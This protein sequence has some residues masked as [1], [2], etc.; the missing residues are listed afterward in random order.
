[1]KICQLPIDKVSPYES[2]PRENDHAVAKVAASLE[3]FGWQQPIVIDSDSVII[4]GHT[5]WLAAKSLDM[6]KVPCV[7]AD[8]LS[9]E[10]VKAYRIAD[11]RIAAES[12]WNVELLKAELVGLKDADYDL[13]LTGFDENE[14]IKYLVDSNAGL[15]EPD[16]VPDAP[17]DPVTQPGDLWLFGA[18]WECDDCGKRYDYEDG[19]TMDEC[20]C[21]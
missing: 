10:Q 16:E 20:P 3:Q 15:A 21:G 11:N 18:Y 19:K 1:V 14:I 17:A 7:V 13:L 6:K 8:N 2:N 4:A 9:A 12:D 5:R